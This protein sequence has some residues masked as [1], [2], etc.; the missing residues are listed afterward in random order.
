MQPCLDFNGIVAIFSPQIQKLEE[1]GNSFATGQ[2]FGACEAFSKQVRDIEG[3]IITLYKLAA[4]IAKATKTL[5]D[6]AG[7]WASMEAF[8]NNAMQCLAP[9]KVKYP[10]CWTPQV[11]DLSLDY[12]NACRRRYNN[13]QEEISCAATPPPEGMFP[14][15][16]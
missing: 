12:V 11:Y 5:K 14:K 15:E 4:S 10:Q 3:T 6:E 16:I 8:C 13:I 9:L 1:V 2:E 7:V